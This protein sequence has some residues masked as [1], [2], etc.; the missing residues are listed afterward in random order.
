[1]VQRHC[2]HILDDAQR[3]FSVTWRKG[4]GKIIGRDTVPWMASWI[5]ARL[6]VG[7]SY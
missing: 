7:R 4:A 3:E 2:R 5:S 6:G 1:M